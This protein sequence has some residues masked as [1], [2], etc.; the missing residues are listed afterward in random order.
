MYHYCYGDKDF[1]QTLLQETGWSSTSGDVKEAKAK[2]VSQ[3]SQFD[4]V[5]VQVLQYLEKI[6]ICLLER[7]PDPSETLVGR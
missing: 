7:T 2:L 6:K 3:I 4:E 5:L 1:L